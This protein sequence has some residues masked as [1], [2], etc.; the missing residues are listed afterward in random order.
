MISEVL[1]EK[2][3]SYDLGKNL[4]VRISGSSHGENV[5]AEISGVPE[6]TALD[7]TEIERFLARRAPGR[8]RLTSARKEDD[9]PVFEKG[10]KDG[11]TDGGILRIVIP[12]KDARSSDY[13]RI[14]DT[15]RPSHADY[16]AWVKYK[17][18]MDMAG[19]G[20]FSGRMTAPLCAAG[21]VALQML[22]KEGIH[23]GA[24]LLSVGDENDEPY[25]LYPSTELL[26][27]AAEKEIPAISE[28][29]GDR[30][31]EII[32]AAGEN[33]DSVGGVVECA[34]IGAPAGMGGPLFQGLEGAISYAVFG[35]PGVKGIEFGAGFA[36][37]A[38]R[39]SQCND[40]FVI[41][42]GEIRTETN[43]SGGIQGGITN[44]MPV[45]FRAAFK[46]TPSISLPQKTVSLSGMVP[47]M[48]KTEG[49]HDPCIAVRAVPVVE[50]A[51][52][53]AV[54][55]MLMEERK[56]GGSQ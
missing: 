28:D 47:E 18:E 32:T 51:A 9:R 43:N 35:I 49:R 13:E 14:K 19:G 10:L 50:A 40:P 53:L 33:G 11:V 37:S 54:L 2:Q 56:N 30:M 20:P 6:G 48:I 12:N 1:E 27:S 21:A 15:P 39:G 22:W 17:G 26:Q 29:A 31:R 36:A 44:G 52:A 25:P 23:V 42:D 46:P 5:A 24:H 45:V 41:E 55:D 3:M 4:I 7:I 8:S 34:V 38:M 16:T